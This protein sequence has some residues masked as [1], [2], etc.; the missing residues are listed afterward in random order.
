MQD[1][2]EHQTGESEF[3][4]NIKLEVQQLLERKTREINHKSEGFNIV[5]RSA[6]V[7]QRLGNTE[8]HCLR[9]R[10]F[11]LLRKKS[12]KSKFVKLKEI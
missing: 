7:E 1:W 2:L 6:R 3:Y 10:G 4:Q 11:K 12:K 5:S 8:V 9:G